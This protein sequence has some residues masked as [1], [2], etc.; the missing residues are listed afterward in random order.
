MCIRDS[1]R[2]RA[3]LAAGPSYEAGI[4]TSSSTRQSGT[5][6][7]SDVASAALT[8]VAGQAAPPEA[9][10]AAWSV[11]PGE[12]SAAERLNT[13][14]ASAAEAAT[15]HEHAQ[16]FSVLLDVLHYLLFFALGG[17]LLVTLHERLGRAGSA[18]VHRILGWVGLGLAV[19][20]M[21]SFLACLLY[22]SPSPRD[23]TRS[24]MPSSA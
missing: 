13:L 8:R 24:R 21:G 12:G 5:A 23:R 18:R 1:S 22:T 3:L 16:T 4:L 2:L 9:A 10:D 7:L 19:I 11:A 17:L 15:V 6:Q 14:R 20:P